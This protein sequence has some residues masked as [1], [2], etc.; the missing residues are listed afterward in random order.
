L[1]PSLRI[2]FHDGLIKQL[3]QLSRPERR[4]VGQ[5]IDQVIAS[6]GNP[7]LHGGIGLRKLKDSLFECRSGL[8][9]RLVFESRPDGLLYFHMIGN[10]DEVLK[11]LKAHR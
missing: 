1:K 2:S 7:H 4:I 6:F 8:K 9:T 10:H 11:F 3:R 5:V